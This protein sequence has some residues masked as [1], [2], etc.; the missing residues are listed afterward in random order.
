MTGS[1]NCRISTGEKLCKWAD[2]SQADLNRCFAI[3][4]LLI[5]VSSVDLGI[6]SLAAAPDGPAIR[7]RLCAKA[8]SMRFLSCSA[9]SRVNP[10]PLSFARADFFFNDTATTEKVP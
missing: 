5:F 1:D 6:P 4:S 7:P 2:E 9:P 8:D 3:P 10:L